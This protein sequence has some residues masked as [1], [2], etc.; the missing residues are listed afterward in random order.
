MRGFFSVTTS[1][2]FPCSSRWLDSGYMLSTV[3]WTYH[4]CS[5]LGKVYDVYYAC[6]VETTSPVQDERLLHLSWW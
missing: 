4:R 3:P 1:G 6:H 5:F 2:S